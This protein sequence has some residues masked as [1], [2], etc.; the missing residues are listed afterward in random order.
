MNEQNP[1]PTGGENGVQ[2]FE[3]PA[4]MVF[5]GETWVVTPVLRW[6]RVTWL[7]SS[8]EA[9]GHKLQQCWHDVSTGRVEWLDVLEVAADA[10]D[11][12]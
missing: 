2:I 3:C 4:P 7:D 1:I 8:L 9:R 5:H 10:P 11:D 6:K 12:R